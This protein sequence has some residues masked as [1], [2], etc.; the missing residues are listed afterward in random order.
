MNQFFDEHSAARRMLAVL[1]DAQARKDTK[2][3][4]ASLH[5]STGSFTPPQVYLNQDLTIVSHCRGPYAPPSLDLSL[6]GLAQLLMSTNSAK[7][8]EGT[9]TSKRSFSS[10][11]VESS[12]T[13]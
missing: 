3:N 10:T 4:G 13:S 6:P 11:E 8:L 9:L 12:R 5:A 1:C 7:A 2:P